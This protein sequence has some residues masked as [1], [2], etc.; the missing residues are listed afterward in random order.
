MMFL[1]WNMF[2]MFFYDFTSF[3]KVFINIH[4]YTNSIIYIS[5]RRKKKDAYKL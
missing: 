1:D 2:L 4:E 5:N 3:F